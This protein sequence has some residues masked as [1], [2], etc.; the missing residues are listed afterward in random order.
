[1]SVQS[2]L[3]LYQSGAAADEPEL[4]SIVEDLE[5][6]LAENGLVG[7][8]RRHFAESSSATLANLEFQS[9]ID[10]IH[11]QLV[12]LLTRFQELYKK[13]SKEERNFFSSALHQ[14]IKI[15]ELSA[16][17]FKE[18]QI[19]KSE[20]VELSAIFADEVDILFSATCSLSA[21]ASNSKIGTHLRKLLVSI[22]KTR[23][24]NLFLRV[25]TKTWSSGLTIIK[26]C[27]TI[28]VAG[29]T[30]QWVNFCSF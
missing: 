16:K 5:E 11:K 14:Q 9:R 1:M 7:S 4:A 29:F 21:H 2:D 23:K 24:T 10:R 8:L 17:I 15:C 22:L 12:P 28:P 3:T 19:K 18:L 13:E 25:N 6:L 26:S 30:G 27:P 20:L